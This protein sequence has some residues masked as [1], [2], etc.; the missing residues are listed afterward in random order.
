MRKLLFIMLLFLCVGCNKNYEE[1]YILDI[2]N[3]KVTLAPSNYDKDAHEMFKEQI[4]VKELA[5]KVTYKE[6]SIYTTIKDEKKKSKTTMKSVSLKE[7]E[8]AVTY[9]CAYVRITLNKDNQIDSIT[10]WGEVIVYE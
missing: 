2:S 9:D 1:Y 7:I 10:L 4:I 5:D 6:I 8:E 3:Q